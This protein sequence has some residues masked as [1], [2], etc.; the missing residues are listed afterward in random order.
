MRVAMI[1]RQPRLQLHGEAATLAEGAFASRNRVPLAQSFAVPGD[2]T[3]FTVVANHFK[4]KGCNEAE[5]A[6]SDQRDG[7]VCWNATRS[8]AAQELHDW[9]ATDPTASGGAASVILGDLNSYAQEDPLRLLYEAGW[10]DAFAQAGIQ[11]PYS[12]NYRGAS[13][14]LDHALLSL[15]WRRRCALRPSGT[16]MPM[17]PKPST[18]SA[19]TARNSGM[20]PIRTA[21]RPRPADPG[22]G[23]R[24]GTLSHRCRARGGG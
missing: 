16:S 3:V 18:T 7:Q 22:A 20:R 2:D 15:N 12:Y 17:N 4:S 11:R 21:P 5:Q 1:Y 13:G 14:R 10:R 19:A 6:D 8:A 23:L 9:L 24:A